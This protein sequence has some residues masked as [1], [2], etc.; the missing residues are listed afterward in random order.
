MFRY[1]PRAIPQ[2]IVV[3]GCGG[4]GSR[5]VPMLAQFIRS[6]TREFNPRGWLETPVIY[7]IDNDVV[8]QKNLLRQNFIEPDV[9]KHKSVVLAQRYSR[10]YGINI[11]PSIHRVG[12]ERI[13]N[14]PIQGLFNNTENCPRVGEEWAHFGSSCMY[15]LCVD[16]AS[17]R[18]DI[19]SNIEATTS[20]AMR[21]RSFDVSQA[22]FI[23]DAG[24]EDTF[25]Q[26][27]FFH[28]ADGYNL[29]NNFQRYKP[30][31]TPVMQDIPAIPYPREVY[32]T[33]EDNNAP[34]C[35]DL[36]QTLAIN[37]SMATTMLG[38]L[39]SFYYVKPFTFHRVGIS[40]DGGGATSF[41]TFDNLTGRNNR[42]PHGY[43][44]VVDLNKT[45]VA[46]HSGNKKFMDEMEAKAAAARSQIAADEAAKNRP[47][48]VVVEATGPVKRV[49]KVPAPELV[50]LTPA[51]ATAAVAEAPP[52][53]PIRR[54][55]EQV[56]R[57]AEGQILDDQAVAELAEDESDDD[58]E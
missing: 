9:G 49:R 13:G 1:T 2:K 51:G 4:T 31:L 6:I 8:E 47:Q 19:L 26:V 42:N 29:P 24:N 48:E 18:R 55:S 43:L 32:S 14:A 34:S 5:L 58:Q 46:Y 54:P 41:L 20:W 22:P 33:M 10:A 21:N 11:I 15:L 56:V 36:D 37:A 38:I 50:P 17:A 53:Q 39:Q 30:A 52:L 7:L 40:L 12:S 25:G 23:I 45:I 27:Q 35:A 44:P 28:M 57:L 16:S 3:I